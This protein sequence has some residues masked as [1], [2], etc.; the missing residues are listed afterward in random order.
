VLRQRGAIV[1]T[2]RDPGSL[3]IELVNQPLGYTLRIDSMP[4]DGAAR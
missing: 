1:T 4:L 3:H 2:V